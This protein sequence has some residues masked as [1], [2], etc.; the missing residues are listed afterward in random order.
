MSCNSPRAIYDYDQTISFKGFNTYR[1]YPDFQSELSALDETRLI[2]SLR[3][4]M[5]NNGFS[6]SEQPD[7]YV[8]AYSRE[9]IDQNR[10]SVGIGIG[11]GSG[12]V[13]VG[14]SGGIPLENNTK[15]LEIT[16]D[17][18]NAQEDALIWQAVVESKINLN[19]S[20]QERRALFEKIVEKA[21][22]GYPPEKN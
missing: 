19:A 12:N 17:F 2:E 3:E 7:I 4:G 1:L 9:Y 5:K 18:I 13:G 14:V 20:P 21:L 8:N 10:S 11:G 6:I 15:I 16:I 22:E